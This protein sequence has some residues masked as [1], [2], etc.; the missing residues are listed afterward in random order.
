MILKNSFF[1]NNFETGKLKII[2]LESLS[3]SFL[4]RFFAWHLLATIHTTL[5]VMQCGLFAYFLSFLKL[6]N[7]Q[8]IVLEIIPMVYYKARAFKS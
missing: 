3:I 8:G 4:S 7:P 6:P 1:Q 2:K 5:P